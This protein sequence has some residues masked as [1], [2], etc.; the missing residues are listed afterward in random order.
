MNG[1]LYEESE[2]EE[3]LAQPVREDREVT[4]RVRARGVVCEESDEHQGF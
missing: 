2:D 1:Y 3:L 4:K